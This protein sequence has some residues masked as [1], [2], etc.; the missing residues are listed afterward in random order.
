M[1]QL[2]RLYG[3]RTL[4]ALRLGVFLISVVA[5]LSPLWSQNPPHVWSQRFGNLD[6][7]AA[8]AGAVWSADNFF[9]TGN[10]GNTVDFGGEDLTTACGGRYCCDDIFMAKYAQ[11]DVS[12]LDDDLFM[13]PESDADELVINLDF[14]DDTM[15]EEVSAESIVPCRRREAGG[16]AFFR[17][18]ASVFFLE[19]CP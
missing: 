12:V 5:I 17:A 2:H 11:P 13:C 6:D 3:V 4:V 9:I 7:G 1:N 18:A 16:G 19:I 14:F 15:P 10:F 8:R